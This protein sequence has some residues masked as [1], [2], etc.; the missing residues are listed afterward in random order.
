MERIGIMF[1]YILESPILCL[2][3]FKN[4]IIQKTM[5]NI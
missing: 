1:E 5:K 2:F 3:A 4:D